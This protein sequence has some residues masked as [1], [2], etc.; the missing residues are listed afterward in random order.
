M[1][2]IAR[3]MVAKADAAPVANVNKNLT[4]NATAPTK[5][6]ANAVVNAL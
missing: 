5:P 3:E 1:A 6:A 2:A 4:K